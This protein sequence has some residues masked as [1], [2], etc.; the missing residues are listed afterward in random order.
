MPNFYT[1]M[2]SVCKNAGVR[3]FEILPFSVGDVFAQKLCR[4]NS[5]NTDIVL[6]KLILKSP[7]PRSGFIGSF[8]NWLNS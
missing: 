6:D 2:K 8:I 7:A 1:N 4:F 5:D 3:D